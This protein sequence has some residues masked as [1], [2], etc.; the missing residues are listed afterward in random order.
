MIQQWRHLLAA[1]S[2]IKKMSYS[3]RD[4]LSFCE[5]GK[6]HILAGGAIQ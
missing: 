2:P 1:A 5:D 3:R 4:P 6:Q